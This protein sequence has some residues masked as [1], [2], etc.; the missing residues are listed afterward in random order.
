[1]QR[2]PT[3]SG[4]WLVNRRRRSP[5]IEEM[6]ISNLFIS[7]ILSSRLCRCLDTISGLLLIRALKAVFKASE[8]VKKFSKQSVNSHEYKDTGKLL[9]ITNTN[10]QSCMDFHL[11]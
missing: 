9:T 6:S 5:Q 8:S 3:S 2:Q 11:L 10:M 7:N 4:N 1:M